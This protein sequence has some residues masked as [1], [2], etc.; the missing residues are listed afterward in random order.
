MKDRNKVKNIIRK[1]KIK[2]NHRSRQTPHIWESWTKFD[3]VSFKNEEFASWSYNDV[4]NVKVTHFSAF[5]KNRC[6]A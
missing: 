3:N 2:S 4:T 6:N 1:I 5:Q